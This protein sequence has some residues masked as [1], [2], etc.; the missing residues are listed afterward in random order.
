MKDLSITEVSV[1]I[2]FSQIVFLWLRTLNVKYTANDNVWGAVITGNGI[3]IAWMI[4]IAIGANAMMEGQVMPIVM[5][6]IGGTIG[7]I[8]GMRKRKRKFKRR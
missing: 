3:A 2:F 8:L 1:I 7:T 5:H 6:L 4:G